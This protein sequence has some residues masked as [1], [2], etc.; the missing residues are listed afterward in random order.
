MSGC[1]ARALRIHCPIWDSDIRDGVVSPG[2][3]CMKNCDDRGERID[4]DV[5][6]LNR[7]GYAQEL[8]R[9]MGGFSNFA[10]SMSVI[11]ILGRRRHVVPPRLLQRRRG[12]DRP[13]VAAGRLFSL[14]VAVDDGTGRLGLPDRRRPVSLVVDP[15]RTRL[16]LGHRLV[17][18]RGLITVLAA[19]NVGTCRFALGDARAKVWLSP[20]GDGSSSAFVAQAIGVLLITG[21]QAPAQ[22]PGHPLTTALTDFSG[23]LILVVALGLT[24]GHA[25]LR[26]CAWSPSRLVTLRPTTAARPAAGSGRRPRAS[27]GCS[28][29]G[30]AARVHDHRLRRLGARG[31]GD[32]RRL[33]RDV[34]RGIVRSVAGLGLAGWVLLSAVVLA[35]P[36]L[37]EAAAQGEGAFV[38]IMRRCC[39]RT[40]ALALY[41]GIALAQYLLRPGD[42]DLGLAD[43]V[44]LRPRRRPALLARRALGLP[45]RNTPAVAIWGVAA[46]VVAASR[47]HPRLL[48]DHRRLHDLPL[49]LV[50]AADGAAAP[51]PTGGPGRRWGPGTSAAGIGRW[52]ASAWS[53]ASCSSPS[54]CSRPTTGPPPSWPAPWS[55]WRP[56]GSAPNATASGDRR[57]SALLPPAIAEVLFQHPPELRD[58]DGALAADQHQ[59]AIGAEV[60]VPLVDLLVG[61]RRVVLRGGDRPAGRPDRRG[62]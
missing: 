56:P 30:P 27:R 33:G 5:R 10:I 21:S 48:H 11:C 53:A 42:G 35:I 46:L 61:P 52:R 29:W 23:Y 20:G 36:N 37:D 58:V 18:P 31:R 3:P 19:I 13:G 4:A 7:L 62:G 26:A 17:Q 38:W 39:P 59:L 44:R 34:P 41:V 40:L 50:R 25:R 60:A 24:A 14:V 22:S 43:G 9:R 12:S 32:R 2:G 49:R 1:R 6:M 16:G 55:S 15:G 8:R 51:G 45:A 47:S 54:A 28:C 57:P